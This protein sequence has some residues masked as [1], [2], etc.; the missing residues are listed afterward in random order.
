MWGQKGELSSI[1]DGGPGGEYCGVWV[2]RG[3][4]ASFID[5]RC[6]K[7]SQAD[8]LEKWA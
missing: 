8:C 7:H 1:D 2:E 4:I 3:L 5:D 6:R